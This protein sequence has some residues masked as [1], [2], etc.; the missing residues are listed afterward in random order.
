MEKL[1]ALSDDLSNLQDVSVPAY[2]EYTS[3]RSIK[4]TNEI[5][6]AHHLDFLGGTPL[7]CLGS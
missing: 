2:P 5:Q 1:L 7:L 3:R 4:M 6:L